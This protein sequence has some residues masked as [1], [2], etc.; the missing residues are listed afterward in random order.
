MS[1][2]D[3]VTEI[4]VWGYAP[5]GGR[6]PLFRVWGYAPTRESVI[7]HI[8]SHH[9]A[10]RG[11]QVTDCDHCHGPSPRP[12]PNKSTTEHLVAYITTHHESLVALLPPDTTCADLFGEVENSRDQDTG[13]QGYACMLR[14][15]TIYGRW[16]FR[17]TGV[18][19]VG[20]PPD[21]PQCMGVLVCL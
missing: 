16:P 14:T 9:V 2:Y 7:S 10:R 1:G 5:A 13:S 17:G 18:C 19:S 3:W 8:L 21:R 12:S 11:Q 4:L 15:H 20:R 6:R